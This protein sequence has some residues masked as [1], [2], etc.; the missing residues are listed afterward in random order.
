MCAIRDGA[1]LET[2]ET[3]QAA[4]VRIATRRAVGRQTA[5]GQLH[6]ASRPEAAPARRFA[7]SRGVEPARPPHA[8][9]LGVAARNSESTLWTPGWPGLAALPFLQDGPC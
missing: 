7:K 4:P 6:A 1:H 8:A 5:L 9:W 3:E 2:E